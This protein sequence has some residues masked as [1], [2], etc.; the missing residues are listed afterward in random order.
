MGW[1][2]QHIDRNVTLHDLA[3]LNEYWRGSP[4]VHVSVAGYLG[5][6]KASRSRNTDSA[7]SDTEAAAVLGPARPFTPRVPIQGA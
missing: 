6:G 5:I 1:T 7:G 2:F 3:A 4:P